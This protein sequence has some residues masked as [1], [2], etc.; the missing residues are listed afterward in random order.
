MTSHLVAD[1]LRQV[2]GPFATEALLIYDG[3]CPVC[4]RYVQFVRLRESVGPVRLIDARDGGPEV[5]QILK[6]GLDLDEGMVLRI[7]S[8]FY[9]GDE[10]V[11]ALALLSTPSTAFNRLN[12]WIFR[13][14]G[15]SKLLY[16]FLRT[17]RNAL[18]R[19]L[20]RTKFSPHV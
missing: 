4:S 10:C 17:G 2:G 18:L 19:L 12:G 11:H 16:P 5:E 20:G 3:D 15:R 1:E 6:A 14:R 7:G 8:R 13:S 9:H